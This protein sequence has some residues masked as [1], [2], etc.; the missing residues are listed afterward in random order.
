MKLEPSPYE[1]VLRH[2]LNTGS[3]SKEFITFDDL[4]KLF[5]HKSP[6]GQISE[7]LNDLFI[8]SGNNPKIGINVEDFIK[9]FVSQEKVLRSKVDYIKQELRVL[10]NELINDRSELIEAKA[11]KAPED[12]NL[13]IV[14]VIQ[15]EFRVSEQLVARVICDEWEVTTNPIF[16]GQL[17]NETFTFN[18]AS[19]SDIVIEFWTFVNKSLNSH[20]ASIQIP[21]SSLK[22]EEPIQKWFKIV[23]SN[24][25][26][27]QVHIKLL[28]VKSKIDYFSRKVS[29]K[30]EKI[31]KERKNLAEA[32]EKHRKILNFVEKGKNEGI[33]EEISKGLDQFLM[34]FG[35]NRDWVLGYYIC[36]YVYVV[37]CVLTVIFGAGGLNVLCI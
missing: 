24:P 13:L 26:I 19:Q 29:E 31:E 33:E 36:L 25:K 30:E 9:S 16:S 12:F 37:V 6:A 27:S 15:A 2:V 22:N 11:N 23:P 10:S 8:E 17:W 35:K 4:L 28:Y 21:F 1:E 7:S 32:E 3:S 34:D 18:P 14:T 5:S 20:L